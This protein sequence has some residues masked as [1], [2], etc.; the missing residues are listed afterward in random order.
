MRTA[1]VGVAAVHR[2]RAPVTVASRVIS[3]ATTFPAQDSSCRRAT[4][5]LRWCLDRGLRLVKQQMLMTIGLYN[6]P[7]GA[8]L[9]SILL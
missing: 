4:T 5:V 8:Y 9:P 3:A 7:A 1:G 6:D 2:H